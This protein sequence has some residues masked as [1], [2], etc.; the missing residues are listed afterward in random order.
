MAS[1][2]DSLVAD[3]RKVPSEGNFKELAA[4]L[5]QYEEQLSKV[6]VSVLDTM[7]EC[8]D[9]SSHSLGVMAAL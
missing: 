5:A 1:F 3:I 7:V 4:K 6:D 9:V 8:L 2:V